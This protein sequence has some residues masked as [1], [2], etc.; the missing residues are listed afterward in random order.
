MRA[1]LKLFEREDEGVEQFNK[2]EVMS[3]LQQNEY[4]S[5]EQSDTEDESRTR[6]SNEKRF[7]HVYDH[8]WRS[9]IA[10]IFAI[11]IYDFFRILDNNLTLININS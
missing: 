11:Y 3:I 5:L 8:L 10:S 6:Q 7:I 4:H 1:A 9:E 2:D